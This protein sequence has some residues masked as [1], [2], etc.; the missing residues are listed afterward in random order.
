[1]SVKYKRKEGDSICSL[2]A[3]TIS[4]AVFFLIVQTPNFRISYDILAIS[5]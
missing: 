1:M 3:I 2:K 5:R 4:A